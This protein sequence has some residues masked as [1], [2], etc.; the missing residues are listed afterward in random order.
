MSK[1]SKPL[2][3]QTSIFDLLRRSAGEAAPSEGQYN[4]I[5][6]LRA[7]LR[8][9]IKRSPLDRYRI[10][11]E[12]SHLLGETITKEMIDSWTRE[13]N[14]EGG[15]SRRHIP[16]EYLP[17]FCKATGCNEPMRELCQP[18]EIYI[19]PGPEALRAEIQKIDERLAE[20]KAEKKERRLFLKRIEDVK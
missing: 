13:T 18:L 4:V 17:A 16:G 11:G 10:A 5:G 9:A 20:L 1:S 14:E 8:N 3:A 15:R 7:S 12:M 6:L 19:L 2:D